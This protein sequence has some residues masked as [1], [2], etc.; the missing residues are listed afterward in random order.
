MVRLRHAEMGQPDGQHHNTH[1]VYHLQHLISTT[2]L[3]TTRP[4]PYRTLQQ[5]TRAERI[6]PARKT[7]AQ[8]ARTQHPYPNHIPNRYYRR[9][10]RSFAPDAAFQH[11]FR[12]TLHLIR[13]HHLGSPPEEKHR[14]SLSTLSTALQH[15]TT[16]DINPNNTRALRRRLSH[17][18]TPPPSN[19]P[20]RAANKH[21]N[22]YTNHHQ[23]S[24]TAEPARHRCQPK[25]PRLSQ[26]NPCSI[27]IRD[28][29]TTP[30]IPHAQA[31][32]STDTTA[33]APPR[34][35]TPPKYTATDT[36]T[37][38]QPPPLAPP[39]AQGTTTLTHAPDAP[40]TDESCPAR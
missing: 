39:L 7:I 11:L 8:R 19:N 31:S 25:H 2:P 20:S 22:A 10:Q 26:R 34:P 3:N 37:P 35:K 29:H 1:P 21:P 40:T 30:P 24:P 17:Q 27:H 28:T 5:L 33:P 18:P 4:E 38:P 6:T 36:E 16:N 32:P 12:P 15:F 14:I 9:S 13:V 23:H